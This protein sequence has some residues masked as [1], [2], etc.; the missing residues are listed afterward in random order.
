[1]ARLTGHPLSRTTRPNAPL[2]NKMSAH[3]AERSSCG[4]RTT[5]S[6]AV[7]ASGAQSRGARVRVPSMYAT[8]RPCCSALVTTARITVV[9]PPPNDP[10]SSVSRP[11]GMP[12]LGSAPSSAARPVATTSPAAGGGAT[13][14][15][16]CSR[17][18][19][20][21]AGSKGER[22]VGSG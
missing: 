4:G 5:Q 13:T 10:T 11:Q 12:P 3:H 6:R 8:H 1:M 14:A 20:R 21:E 9:L 2:R 17:S 19:A 15:E 16:S 18:V 7:S 22:G